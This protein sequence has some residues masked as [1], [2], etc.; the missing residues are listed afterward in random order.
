[1]ANLMINDFPAPTTVEG[2][3]FV[4][5]NF[6][7]INM[8]ELPPPLKSLAANYFK[9]KQ[10]E[11]DIRMF[12]NEGTAMKIVVVPCGS[13]AHRSE[14]VFRS[15]G[16]KLFPSRPSENE[17]SA[18]GGAFSFLV[19][20]WSLP[21]KKADKLYPSR[22][23]KGT[24]PMRRARNEL[25]DYVRRHRVSH[26][27][28]KGTIDPKVL[29]KLHSN[30]VQHQ[31]IM[32]TAQGLKGES[33]HFKRDHL[34]ELVPIPSRGVGG[35]GA[36]GHHERDEE[37]GSE[38]DYYEED[39]AMEVAEQAYYDEVEEMERREFEYR[40]RDEYHYDEPLEELEEPLFMSRDDYYMAYE[41]SDIN[42]NDIV[43][44]EMY[45]DD[46]ERSTGIKFSDFVRI[47]PTVRP[48]NSFALAPTL[49]G[50]HGEWTGMDD[51]IILVPVFIM[52]FVRSCGWSV[53]FAIMLQIS[54]C[55]FVFFKS[56]I[57][58]GEYVDQQ[59]IEVR[60]PPAHVHVGRLS[61]FRAGCCA[62]LVL[63]NVSMVA[64]SQE[65]P[66]WGAPNACAAL[67]T[68]AAGFKAAYRK[69]SMV[70][71]PDKGGSNEEMVNLN[72]IK[73][74]FDQFGCRDHGWTEGRSNGGTGG[75]RKQE[76]GQEEGATKV[77][78]PWIMIVVFS[79]YTIFGL[80][81]LILIVFSSRYRNAW[82]TETNA[83]LW[84]HTG[85]AILAMLLLVF[86]VKMEM[87]DYVMI[88]AQSIDNFILVYPYIAYYKYIKKFVYS[89]GGGNKKTEVS[90]VKP[91]GKVTGAGMPLLKKR[92]VLN[93][94]GTGSNS[95]INRDPVPFEKDK[96]KAKK[97]NKAEAEEAEEAEEEGIP[98]VISADP[99]IR[100]VF[101]QQGLPDRYVFYDCWAAPYCGVAA[102]D[103][104]FGRPGKLDY[105]E[106]LTADAQP[107]N[108]VGIP[109]YLRLHSSMRGLNLEIY[110]HHGEEVVLI[111]RAINSPG[112]KYV[113]LLY[114]RPGTTILN[115]L[116]LTETGEEGEVGHY[117]LVC[118]STS[119]DP[120]INVLANFNVLE[121][122]NPVL[123][124][125]CLVTSSIFFLRVLR[126]IFGLFYDDVDF[127]WNSLF[128]LV[129]YLAYEV[130]SVPVFRVVR[131]LFMPDNR[132][133]RSVFDRRDVLRYQDSYSEVVV[134]QQYRFR[135]YVYNRTDFDWLVKS[136]FYRTYLVSNV[137]FTQTF[138]E[139]Q[140]LA[141]TGR[142]PKL[143]LSLISKLREVNTDIC[144]AA[145]MRDTYDLLMVICQDLSANGGPPDTRGMLTYNAN[146]AGAIVAGM[147]NIRINQMRGAGNC[148]NHIVRHVQK[149]P[150][151][152]IPVGVAPIGVAY[153][154]DGYQ[155][156]GRYSL[157]DSAGLLVAFA[158]RSMNKLDDTNPDVLRRF[159]EYGKRM[160]EEFVNTCDFSGMVEPDLVE[161][162][163]TINKG[164]KT[165]TYIQG[166]IK[167]YEKYELGHMTERE[168][169]DF[170]KCRMFVKFEH[171]CKSSGGKYKT[172]P[173]GIMTMSDRW[174]FELCPVVP[175]IDKWNH[176]GFSEHQI[177]DMD[178][179]EMLSKVEEVQNRNHAVTD[180]SSFES[181]CLYSIRRIEMYALQLMC[182]RAGFTRL[183]QALDD[184]DHPVML[185][186][187]SSSFKISTRNS[188]HYPT[189]FG[190]GITNGC[191]I[192]FMIKE[193]GLDPN[194]VKFIVEGDDGLC[195]VR[196]FN[197]EIAGSLGFKLSDEVY[198]SVPGDAD[199]LRSLV[200]D[201]KRYLNIPRNLGVLWVKKGA[202]LK[203]SKQLFLLRCAA[204]SLYHMSPGHPVLTAV[205]N[206]IGYETR[207]G[208][209]KFRGFEKYLDNSYK[210]FDYG[211]GF[212]K[213][214]EVDESMRRLIAEGAEGFPA[215]SIAEQLMIE[216]SFN[217][218]DNNTFYVGRALHDY[219]D[220]AEKLSEEET[221]D[222]SEFF[223]LLE[224]IAKINMTKV[225]EKER[226]YKPISN[227][228]EKVDAPFHGVYGDS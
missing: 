4:Y 220:W 166:K 83:M 163:K 132:D 143:A 186:T 153:N 54:I 46:I 47:A 23:R 226:D 89:I 181:S 196:A 70:C 122:R 113:K 44:W 10:R 18:S 79:V 173:R 129:V 150:K 42:P 96:A 160:V 170:N 225:L 222:F 48:N 45:I 155:T 6:V 151:T 68:D 133:R 171:T 91:S 24:I 104:G 161:C 86:H 148:G 66:D 25:Y 221:E 65:R 204:N 184:Y 192:G 214:V 71:H 211:K 141:G 67:Y 223:S 84:K 74:Q 193:M 93:N 158:G 149:E 51:V 20:V 100:K 12:Q 140:H 188:G 38:M 130:H 218:L 135:E 21:P 120:E 50:A 105:Y 175:L 87:T 190:N 180:Y 162:F 78:L 144:N 216:E 3:H 55:V 31:R 32:A 2:G 182:E 203:R 36:S 26:Q 191:V 106:G 169:E 95:K 199:F 217:N 111:Y 97:V 174:L 8:Q 115:G 99:N 128:V 22:P 116:D 27:K 108:V 28:K 177:K 35:L 77:V 88:L 200:K 136:S 63:A 69:Y 208:V 198:G 7:K 58:G 11:F 52:N 49:N 147:D 61:R 75:S 125:A 30:L 53:L 138:N 159:I 206:R 110:E 189:S 33:G 1:M 114:A 107:W 224:E 90:D 82:D 205:V 14:C 213:H 40:G 72:R 117:F 139:M 103:V 167:D 43:P 64:A 60:F 118:S 142:E 109:E 197:L 156:M 168:A 228:W 172:K 179:V 178:V 215:I 137:R 101:R 183:K 121:Y 194:C 134:D 98:F 41:G 212:P 73:D 201:G 152:G 164:K 209:N 207:K 202:K 16:A 37:A 56:F 176:G 219:P 62:L 81:P 131:E 157:T 154:T 39:E 165:A 5:K 126:T 145:V 185:E 85:V 59:G 227:K 15:E 13:V 80:S 19:S 195:D 119:D 102:I 123:I 57:Y 34:R 112:F 210:R 146:N 92:R 94:R 124:K 9:T 187:V 17:Y 76:D 29:G 127:L